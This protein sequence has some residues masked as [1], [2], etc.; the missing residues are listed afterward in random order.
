MPWPEVR[1]ATAEPVA[2]AARLVT[3]EP[4]AMPAMAEPER[5][6][7]QAPIPK[8]RVTTAPPAA[9]AAMA[10]QVVPVEPFQASAA[11][12]ASQATV[13]PAVRAVPVRQVSTECFLENPGATEV[14][15][16]MA[17]TEDPED[18]EVPGELPREPESP[19]PA[20]RM[21]TAA[22]AAWVPMAARAAMVPLA[23]PCTLTVAMA[24]RVVRAAS[25][26]SV[27]LAAARPALTESTA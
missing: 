25:P 7:P 17:Q 8:M 18:L 22:R 4:A 23:I 1:A 3:A 15:E 21:A 2:V 12:A 13:A 26:A 20:V 14:P 6:E 11:M 24:A 27:G 19:A 5:L 9:M 16:G 10:A